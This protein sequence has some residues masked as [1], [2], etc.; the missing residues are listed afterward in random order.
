MSLN[1][2]YLV[3]FRH[4]ADHLVC[5]IDPQ[6]S[7][8]TST[9]LM[10][11]TLFKTLNARCSS[12]FLLPLMLTILPPVKSIESVPSLNIGQSFPQAII[13]VTPLSSSSQLS[14]VHS[15]PPPQPHHSAGKKFD[16]SSPP[17]PR[18]SSHNPTPSSYATAST[19][20]TSRHAC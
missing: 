3:L 1:S 10:I 15:S 11:L 18:V 7:Y 8:P 13:C 12:F 5:L 16:A 9:S 14:P 2:P 17:W 20:G 6:L 4:I 19:A